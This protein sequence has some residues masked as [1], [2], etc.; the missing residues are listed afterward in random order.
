L[1]V[2]L[3]LIDDTENSL[4]GLSN[5]KWHPETGTPPPN[6]YVVVFKLFKFF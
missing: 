3:Y 5:V 1:F 4:T 6:T 2:I